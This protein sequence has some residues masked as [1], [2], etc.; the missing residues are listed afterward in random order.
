MPSPLSSLCFVAVDG[1]SIVVVV[2]AALVADA[3][4]Y[5]KRSHALGGDAAAQ[6]DAIHSLNDAAIAA[7]EVAEE[8]V[9][10]ASRRS[11]PQDTSGGA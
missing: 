8:D 10:R 2:A 6:M 7:E 5:L 3:A 4:A 9:P 1:V 11:R